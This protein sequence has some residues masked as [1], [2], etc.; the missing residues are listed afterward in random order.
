MY[1]YAESSLH[2]TGSHGF[3]HTVRVLNLCMVIGESEP[4][5]MDILIP[6]ALF[7]DI[8]RP[9]EEESGIPHEEKGAEIAGEYLRSAAYPEEFI[10]PVTQAIRA[11]RFRSGVIPDTLEGRIL[12][13]ADKLDAMGATG[14]ARTFLSAGERKDGIPEAMEHIQ[15]KLLKLKDRMHTRTGRRLAGE[16]HRLLLLFYR[17]M[18]EEMDLRDPLC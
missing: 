2:Q 13:D 6:A 8:A 3:D 14:I 18:Q 15:D 17:K 10:L 5:N 1:E 7:H 9:Q 16:R 12:S 4:A 11:H